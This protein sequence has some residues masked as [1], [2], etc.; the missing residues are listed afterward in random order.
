METI[1]YGLQ[2]APLVMD[3]CSPQDLSIAAETQN[4]PLRVLFERVEEEGRKTCDGTTIF[5][6]RPRSMSATS[7]SCTI[8]CR[9]DIKKLK[10]KICPTWNNFKDDP[11]RQRMNQL[12]E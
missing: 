11:E 6:C 8:T 12:N 7:K 4:F 10:E 1:N 9:T 3:T 2:R 5:K